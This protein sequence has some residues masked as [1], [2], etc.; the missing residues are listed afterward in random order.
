M[1]QN[2]I[3]GSI[4]V[5]TR[6][7]VS[8]FEEHEKNNLQW[9]II[10][11]VI[12]GV[13]NAI[14][15]AALAPLYAARV[16]EQIADLRAQAD[17]AGGSNEFIDQMIAS[18]EAS[19]EPNFVGAILG[20][21]IGTAIGF[22][23]YTGLVYLLGR[24]FGGSGQFGELA[25]DL[26]L[27]AAPLSVAGVLLNAIPFVGG[28]VGFALGIY[29]IF[30]TYLAIQSGMNLDRNKAIYV[31]V[32]LFVVGFALVCGVGL[33]IGGLAAGLGALSNQ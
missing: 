5:L 13:I 17:A 23:I 4:A 11:S 28:I 8:T 18:L 3:N 22:L 30:L 20:A 7:S 2:M 31:M 19:T 15:N 33:L 26:A 10:Y 14:I 6:P 21:L 25:Y 12:A 32:I 9:A 16:N 24:A 1:F 29:N 27:F